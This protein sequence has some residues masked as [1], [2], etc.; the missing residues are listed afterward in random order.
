LETPFGIFHVRAEYEKEKNIRKI[1]K[2]NGKRKDK[3][4]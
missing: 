3:W 1:R 2:K 4:K